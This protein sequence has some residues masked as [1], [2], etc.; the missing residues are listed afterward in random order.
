LCYYQ[1]NVLLSNVN[2]KENWDGCQFF[3]CKIPISFAVVVLVVVLVV[4]VSVV[5]VVVMVVVVV[6]VNIW[7]GYFKS[8]F[9]CS[10]SFFKRER[11]NISQSSIYILPTTGFELKSLWSTSKALPS[12]HLET[13]YY[14]LIWFNEQYC[15]R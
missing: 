5:V 3:K 1:K 12:L 2:K 7:R 8:S 14:Y 9:Y 15:K 6:V 11:T 10:L 4:V 13:N